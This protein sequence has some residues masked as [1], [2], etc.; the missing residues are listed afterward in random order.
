MLLR[1]AR[2]G[3]VCSHGTAASTD[4]NARVLASEPAP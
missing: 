2:V 1:G 3:V 4:G